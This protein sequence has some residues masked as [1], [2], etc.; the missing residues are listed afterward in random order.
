MVI[1]CVHDWKR[2]VECERG[3]FKTFV[4]PVFSKKMTGLTKT[5]DKNL[6]ATVDCK[7]SRYAAPIALAARSFA[8]AA[9]RVSRR[10]ATTTRHFSARQKKLLPYRV[11]P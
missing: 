8:A 3:T 7:V 2:H 5:Q 11:D 9:E 10:F 1:G 4:R 6:P